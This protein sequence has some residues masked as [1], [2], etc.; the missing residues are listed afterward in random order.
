VVL[1]LA[2]GTGCLDPLASDR[3]GYSEHVLA[4]GT[5]VPRATRDPSLAR[6]I[7]QGDGIASSPAPTKKGYIAGAEAPYWDLGAAKNSPVPAYEL[8]RC[9]A[10]GVPLEGGALEHPWIVDSAPGDADYTQLWAITPVCITQ[11][12]AGEL[13]SSFSALNDGV[14]LGIVREPGNPASYAYSPIVADGAQ[15]TAFLG[16]TADVYYRGFTL[17]RLV[18]GA[19]GAIILVD[20]RLNTPNVYELLLPGA[21]SPSRIVFALG[22]D[23]PKYAPVWSQITVVVSETADLSSLSA[24]SDLVTIGEDKSMKPASSAIIAVFAAGTRVARPLVGA[25]GQP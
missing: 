18:F 7:D 4:Q 11:Y 10:A 14:E 19:A 25:G 15:L 3:P 9:D 12:Y 8:T 1:A 20:G 21:K 23:S 13:I 24:E 22:S 17:S 6:R 16:P 2:L 5:A